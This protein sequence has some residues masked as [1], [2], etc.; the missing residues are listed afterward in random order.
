[1]RNCLFAAASLSLAALVSATTN[2][3][4]ELPYFFPPN[5]TSPQKYEISVDSL[6]IDETL[7]K[8]K[9]FRPSRSLDGVPDWE[10]G[11]PPSLINDFASYWSKDYDWFAVQDQIN[12]NFSHYAT[13]VPGSRNYMHPIPLHFVHEPSTSPNAIPLL[14][15]HGWPSTFLEW[16]HVIHPLAHPDNS[17]DQSFHVVAVDLPGYG[18]SPAPI[19]THLG[20]REMGDAFDALM[21]QLGYTKYGVQSTDLG[22]WV[23][24]WMVQDHTDSLIGHSTDFWLQAPNATVLEKYA[25]NQTTPEEN[26][27][28]VGIGEFENYHAGYMAIHNTKPLQLSIAMSDSPVG[29]LAW[30]LQLITIVS[31]GY[32]YTKEELIT[33]ALTLYI[34]GA[35]SN[36][37]SYKEV[38]YPSNSIYGLPRTTVPTA[39][40]EWGNPDNPFPLLK[41]AQKAP[42]TWLQEAANITFF[43]Q[44]D[45]CAHFPADT[46]PDEWVVDVREFFSQHV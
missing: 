22:W 44:H 43:R 11:P 21:K 33:R 34:P 41:N 40:T 29:F 14:L 38:F 39:V 18:F 36:I 23:G 13:T 25:A 31:D 37:R 45:H 17:S 24:M 10:D 3:T 20:P 28:I 32:E 16:Q 4:S 30:M 5:A 9:L 12:K 2:A 35:Y 15:L 19:S 42:L 26:E 27:Y 7:Q 6:I 1:M 46:C 8:V